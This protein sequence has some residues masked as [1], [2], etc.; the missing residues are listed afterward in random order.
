MCLHVALADLRPDQPRVEPA[1]EGHVATQ[2]RLEGGGED[3][4]YVAGQEEGLVEGEE[5]EDD[6]KGHSSHQDILIQQSRTQGRDLG[7]RQEHILSIV[8]YMY[9]HVH[10]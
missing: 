3:L 9:I 6:V 1:V 10:D 5:D 8:Q 4:D 2:Q 7:N